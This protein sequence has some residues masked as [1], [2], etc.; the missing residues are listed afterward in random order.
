MQ[1]KRVPDGQWLA[2]GGDNGW[3]ARQFLEMKLC[4]IKEAGT[5]VAA[6]RSNDGCNPTTCGPLLFAAIT[7]DATRILL[8]AEIARERRQFPIRKRQPQDRQARLLVSVG[9][10]WHGTLP[11]YYMS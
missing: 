9:H 6:C 1:E 10:D 11:T 2:S 7:G 3:G 8:G 4:Q 5:R